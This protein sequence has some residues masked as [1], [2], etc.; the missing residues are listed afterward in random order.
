MQMDLNLSPTVPIAT[1]NVKT[2][3]TDAHLDLSNLKVSS[4]DISVGA[5]A[6]WIRLP[7]AAGSTSAHISG[8]AATITIEVPQGVAAQIRHHGGLSTVDIDTDRFPQVSD[9]LYRSRDYETTQNK[10]DLFIETGLT[11][12]E[13]N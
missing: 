5:A 11:T 3:A 7:L 8:G 10:V 6:A 9:G 13:V 12:I 4:L 1:L 2:G